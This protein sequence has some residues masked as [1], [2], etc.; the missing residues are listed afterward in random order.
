MTVFQFLRENARFLSAGGLLSFSS[1]YGQTFFIAIFAAQI[2]GAYGLSDGQWGGIYTLSTTASAILM[3][4][5][6]HWLT[7]FECA[8]L[9]G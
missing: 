4:W 5:A 6:A 8:H 7:G 3:F 9:P 1:C 2:M